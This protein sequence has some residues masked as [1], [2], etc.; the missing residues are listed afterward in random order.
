MAPS[1][2]ILAMFTGLRSEVDLDPSG[3]GIIEVWGGSDALNDDKFAWG[4]S[5]PK[6]EDFVYLTKSMPK[7]ELES[8]E[9]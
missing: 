8:I 4:K 7:V 1:A 3:I 5:N 6:K 9:N 2:T